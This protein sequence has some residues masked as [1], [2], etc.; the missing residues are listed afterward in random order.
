[1]SSAT[2]RYARALFAIGDERKALEET[3]AQIESLAA[4]WASSDE[5]RHLLGNPLYPIER[6]RDILRTVGSRLGLGEMVQNGALLL[7]DRSR[8]AELPLL[9]IQLRSMADEHQGTVRAEVVSAT[10]LSEA[11]YQ[12]LQGEL[13]GITGRKVILARRQDPSLITGLVTRVGDRLYDG[14]AR[15]RL[16]EIREALATH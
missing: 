2:K 1:M 3:V 11:Y 16:A 6:R 5:L 9:A 8:L 4:A 10:E 13:E 14:S 12:R 15:T 7:L